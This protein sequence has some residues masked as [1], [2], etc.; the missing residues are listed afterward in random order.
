MRI[1]CSPA[2]RL[3]VWVALVGVAHTTLPSSTTYAAATL[4]AP[5]QCQGCGVNPGP[6]D[7]D[8]IPLT[9]YYVSIEVSMSAGTCIDKLGPGGQVN[10]CGFGPNCSA[11]VE[12][13]WQVTAG[14]KP[15]FSVTLPNGRTYDR[16]PDVSPIE[17]LTGAGADNTPFGGT[18]TPALLHCGSGS[19]T[20]SISAMGMNAATTGSCDDCVY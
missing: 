1:S 5:D 8:S 9:G 11:E 13:M 2:R 15:T 6:P 20:W 10:G 14:T 16:E 7:E 17:L 19:V 3:L 12:R 4:F 18:E